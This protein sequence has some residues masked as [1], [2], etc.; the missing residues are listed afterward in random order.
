MTLN[1]CRWP[2]H[3]PA[4]T[5]VLGLSLLLWSGCAPRPAPPSGPVLRVSQRN[6]PATLDPQL[7]ALPDE[8]LVLRSLLEGLLSPSPDGGAPLPAVAERWESSS[9]RLTWTF[10]LRHDARWS[11]GDAVT[12][13][14]FVYTIRRA[15]EPAIGAPKA[16]LFY[17]LRNARAFHLGRLKDPAELGAAAPDIHTV[18]LTLER[19]TPQLPALVA[20]G[21][22]L[23]VHAA[24]VTKLGGTR[25]SRWALPGNFVGNGPFILSTW[26]PNREIR[27]QR[28]PAYR[29]L[30]HVPLAGVRF[31]A[32]DNGDTEERA[33]RAGQVDVTMSVP[34]SKLPGYHAPMLHTQPLAETRYLS[35]NCTRPPLD[36]PRVRRALALVLDRAA[37]VGQVL[38]GGQQP[39]FGLVPPGIG[40]Y[41]AS[42]LFATD[43]A[44]ARRLLAAAGFPEG[45][46]FPQLELSTWTNV[47]VLEAIQQMWRRELGIESNIVQHEAKV[48]LAALA[49]GDYVVALVPAIP[50]YDDPAALLANFSADAPLNYPHWHSAAYEK[51]LGEADLAAEPARRLALLHEA[52]KIL[53]AEMPVVPIYFNTRTFLVAPRVQG[54]R[55]DR[56]WNRFY[57][58][59]TLHE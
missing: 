53:L 49:A 50:D 34:A 32:Y 56:L 14:D 48:H 10:H 43:P 44:E 11:N 3:L 40:G 5:T 31:L 8:F 18:V 58:D 47:V 6:E 46:G 57:T 37:L 38:R 45:K 20:S 7:A 13:R 27:V 51:L 55:E 21:P 9:D 19:P 25:E 12:S 54:W 2:R 52:E 42:P 39:A 16:R 35:L 17:V 24:T 36:D 15:L 29:D 41:I 4:L 23:P 33:F 1:R 22:W 59:V 26:E 28:N 30:T